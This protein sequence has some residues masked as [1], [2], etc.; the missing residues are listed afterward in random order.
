MKIIGEK[1]FQLMP[2]DLMKGFIVAILSVLVTYTGQAL[3]K[4]ALPMDAAT[5]QTATINS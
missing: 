1:L 2:K 3:E 4:G 5:S